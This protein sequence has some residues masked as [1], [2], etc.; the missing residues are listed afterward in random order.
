MEEEDKG[1]KGMRDEGINEMITCWILMDFTTGMN[2][3]T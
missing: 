2:E 1:K 3:Y